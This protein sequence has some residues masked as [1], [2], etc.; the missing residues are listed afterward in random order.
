MDVGPG[1]TSVSGGI[2]IQN[3]KAQQSSGNAHYH[4]D[5]GQ[6]DVTVSATVNAGSS[7]SNNGIIARST[8]VNNYWRC[9][10]AASGATGKF[11]ITETASGTST[12]R[13]SATLTINTGTDYAL[14]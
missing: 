9:T 7:V 10:I 6:S 5:S 13:A 4:S 8:D 2:T 1:W 11:K 12:D 14:Q 3:N